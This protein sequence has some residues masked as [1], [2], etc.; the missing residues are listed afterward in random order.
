MRYFYSV[1][2]MLTFACGYISD[3]SDRIPLLGAFC[4]ALLIIHIADRRQLLILIRGYLTDRQARAKRV[5][6][7]RVQHDRD[8]QSRQG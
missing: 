1:N 6:Q 5:T 4:I 2:L 8:V 7:Y 3:A